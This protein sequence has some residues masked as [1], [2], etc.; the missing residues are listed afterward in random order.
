MVM[1][2]IAVWLGY[3]VVQCMIIYVFEEHSGSVFPGHQRMEA[4]CSDRNFGTHQLHY[5]SITR[6][7]VILY[8]SILY[9]PFTA[10]LPYLFQTNQLHVLRIVRQQIYRIIEDTVK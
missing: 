2:H 1:I 5:C 6:K 9:F 7:T 8:L 4:V 3:C 10:S